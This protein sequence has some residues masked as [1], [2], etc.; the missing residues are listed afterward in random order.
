M[1]ALKRTHFKIDGSHY[2]AKWPNWIVCHNGSHRGIK[3]LLLLAR[4]LHWM[5]GKKAILEI[6]CV[7]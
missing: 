7:K 4:T 2:S 6:V 5:F 3:V 1:G